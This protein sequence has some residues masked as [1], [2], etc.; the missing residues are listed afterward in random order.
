MDL[1][2]TQTRRVVKRNGKAPLDFYDGMFWFSD[3][4][5]LAFDCPYGKAGDRLWVREPWAI[6][7][8]SGRLV[9]P[10]VNYR[11]GG[12]LPLVGHADPE[13]W[14]L[15]CNAAIPFEKRE[16]SD[17]GLLK[18]KVKDG[19]RP[20]RFMPRWASRLQL[21]ITE[22]R[23]ERLQNISE[24][25]ARAEGEYVFNS[26]HLIYAETQEQKNA[27]YRSNFWHLW[28]SINGKSHPWQ[29]NPL[30]WAISFRWLQ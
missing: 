13:M 19:W 8:G 21:E 16:V 9:D 1:R 29:T 7:A 23:M 4:D 5:T 15:A 20:A 12:Q 11:A 25:D 30:V 26:E 22:V 28:N 27:V 10:C 17:A 3:G 2:K 24:E 6:A 14:S 18:V